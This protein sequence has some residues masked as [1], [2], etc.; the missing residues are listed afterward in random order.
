MC[1]RDRD[2]A[3]QGREDWKRHGWPDEKVEGTSAKG[4]AQGRV[5]WKRNGWS[6]AKF[7]VPSAKCDQTNDQ[8]REKKEERREEREERREKS[9]ERREKREYITKNAA[10]YHQMRLFEQQQLID[11]RVCWPLGR[12]DG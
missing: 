5:D 4:R 9:A 8:Q 6:D 7:E 11:N 3:A 12:R 1:I 10:R 2:G